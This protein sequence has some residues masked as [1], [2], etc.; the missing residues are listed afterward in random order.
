M[1]IYLNWEKTEKHTTSRF[2]LPPPIFT[3]KLIHLFVTLFVTTP[4][5]FQLSPP[6]P[7]RVLSFFVSRNYPPPLPAPAASESSTP[8]SGFRAVEAAELRR[9]YSQLGEWTDPDKASYTLWIRIFLTSTFRVGSKHL[10][11]SKFKKDCNSSY[12]K[13]RNEIVLDVVQTFCYIYMY[14]YIIY[15]IYTIYIIYIPPPPNLRGALCRSL[16]CGVGWPGADGGLVLHKLGGGWSWKIYKS[17][18]S[19]SV[20]WQHT[21]VDNNNTKKQSPGQSH[22]QHR[23]PSLQHRGIECFEKKGIEGWRV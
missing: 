21:M 6:Q 19:I 15:H 16:A 9:D 2:P 3:T 4:L 12:S 13:G 18:K 23:I 22:L 5:N 7:S 17:P 1:F 11:S 14:M 8:S 10:W 20:S